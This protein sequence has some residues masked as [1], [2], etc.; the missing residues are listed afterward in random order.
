MGNICNSSK[1]GRQEVERK[2]DYYNLEMIISVGY[3]VNSLQIIHDKSI[4]DRL[5][6]TKALQIIKYEVCLYKSSSL[7]LKHLLYFSYICLCKAFVTPMRKHPLNQPSKIDWKLPQMDWKNAV[8]HVYRKV[9]KPAHWIS[10]YF[11]CNCKNGACT[12]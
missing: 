2:I 7:S 9:W 5:N 4:Y 3:R 6:C 8:Q 10:R 1:R 12:V 11:Q